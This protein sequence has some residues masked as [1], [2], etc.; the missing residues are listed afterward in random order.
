MKKVSKSGKALLLALI[1]CGIGLSVYL[2]YIYIKANSP[3]AAS[4]ESFCAMSEEVNCITVA[5]SPY[6]RLFG[7]PIS[8]YGIFNYLLWLFV[9]AASFYPKKEPLFR[10]GGEILFALTLVA[11][12]SSLILGYI[13]KYIISSICIL[14]LA[15]YAVNFLS[16]IILGA[17]LNWRLKKISAALK[18]ELR[19][20]AASPPKRYSFTAVALV[21]LTTVAGFGYGDYKQRQFCAEDENISYGG[22]CKGEPGVPVVIVEFTDYEC[23]HCAKAHEVLNQVYKQFDGYIRVEHKDYPIDMACNPYVTKPFHKWACLAAQYGRCAA[24]Q[25][26][27]WQF[28]DKVFANSRALSEGKLKEIGREVGL[29]VD[30]L[31]SCAKRSDIV[32]EIQKDI[33]EGWL[34]GIKG[35]PVFFVNGEKYIGYR[36]YEFWQELMEKAVEE[37][38]RKK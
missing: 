2:T 26:K 5:Q 30:K 27:F 25:G 15:V 17:S 37:H 14:C 18:D 35:T 3:D 13:S 31:S 22:L 12:I 36:P 6:S 34:K 19:A 9:F 10:K 11:V 29:D 16:F 7:I 1:L 28:H 20:V 38:R 4:Y 32:K 24:E 23:P 33:E 8:V 21:A